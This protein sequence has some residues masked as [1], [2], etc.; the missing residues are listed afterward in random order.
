MD[1]RNFEISSQE[2]PEQGSEAH[3]NAHEPCFL[4]LILK[5]QAIVYQLVKKKK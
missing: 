4:F 3:L 2:P 1:D 5:V